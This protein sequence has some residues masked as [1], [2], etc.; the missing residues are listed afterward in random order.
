[1]SAS[2]RSIVTRLLLSAA[3]VTLAW[4]LLTLPAPAQAGGCAATYT[5]QPGDTLSAIARANGVSV[6][7]LAQINRLHSPY[8]LRAGQTL[9]MPLEATRGMVSLELSHEFGLSP[10]EARVEF[11]IS[12]AAN[13]VSLYNSVDELRNTIPS[14][15]PVILWLAR[16][17]NTLGYTLLVVGETISQTA[18]FDQLNVVAPNVDTQV[19]N[20]QRTK[21]DLKPV[22]ELLAW[23]EGAE[24]ERLPFNIAYVRG[25]PTLAAAKQKQPKVYLAVAGNDAAGYRL[26]VVVGKDSTVIFGPSSEDRQVRCDRWRGRA[27]LIYRLLRRWYRC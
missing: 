8:W 24:G 2:V 25:V 21:P 4:L 27:G 17:N 23:A 16:N 22:A 11:P 26:Y 10:P 13:A 3:L 18:V 9:C 5:V 19:S 6:Q 12:A 1:M 14:D 7:A 15:A 20:L